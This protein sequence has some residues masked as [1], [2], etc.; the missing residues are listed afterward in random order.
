M[1]LLGAR[2]RDSGTAL[3]LGLSVCRFSRLQE[4]SA[5]FIVVATLPDA[6]SFS[7][8][9]VLFLVVSEPYTFLGYVSSTGV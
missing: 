4:A 7:K 1:V 5:K 9:S 3:Y 8:L 2:Q 6:A